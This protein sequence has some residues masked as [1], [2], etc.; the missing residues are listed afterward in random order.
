MHDAKPSEFETDDQFC[1]G[2]SLELK[3]LPTDEAN[4]W[5]DLFMRSLNSDEEKP[6]PGLFVFYGWGLKRRL[7]ADWRDYITSLE[8]QIDA[9][10]Q[11]LEPQYPFVHGVTDKAKAVNI[12]INV[13]GNPHNLGEEVPRIEIA[14]A[15]EFE[16]VAVEGV[17]ARFRHHVDDRARMQSVAC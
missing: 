8:H 2:C 9:L 17:R 1:P 7:N 6:E 14:I 4:L 5:L 13:R 3:A 15:Y 10:K 11:S 16:Q 12:A